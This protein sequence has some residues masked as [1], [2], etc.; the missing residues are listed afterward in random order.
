MMDV[1][2]DDPDDDFWMDLAVKKAKR[3]IWFSNKKKAK[4]NFIFQS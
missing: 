1:G 2:E 4:Y 3:K